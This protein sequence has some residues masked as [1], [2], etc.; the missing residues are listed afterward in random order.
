MLCFMTTISTVSRDW[1]WSN[2]GTCAQA[3]AKKA[4]RAAH[5]RKKYQAQNALPEGVQG[6][7][8]SDTE[9][10]APACPSLREENEAASGEPAFTCV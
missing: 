10:G 7:V 5:A 1:N 6:W 3:T 4:E 9:S 2:F 8:L